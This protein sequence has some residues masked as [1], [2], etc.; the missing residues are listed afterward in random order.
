MKEKYSFFHFFPFVN[1]PWEISDFN[2]NVYYELRNFCCAVQHRRFTVFETVDQKAIIRYRC[3]GNRSMEIQL[4]IKLRDISGIH[5][6]MDNG[7]NR[8]RRFHGL[9]GP[10]PHHPHHPGIRENR[11]PGH[12]ILR[13]GNAACNTATRN[14]RFG[15]WETK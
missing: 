9:R 8:P 1:Q 6:V 12:K 7:A 5:P 15:I 13:P 2:T 14:Y 10:S 4:P 3:S 11:Y